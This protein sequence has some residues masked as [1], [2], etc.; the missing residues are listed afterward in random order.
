MDTE[1][2]NR[3]SQQIRDLPPEEAK[4]TLINIFSELRKIKP[5]D[6]LDEYYE[7]VRSIIM[8]LEHMPI[9]SLNPGKKSAV[10]TTRVSTPRPKVGGTRKQRGG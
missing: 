9:I 6:P 5:L 2:G 8:K 1:L 4:K 3:I 10:K 7:K